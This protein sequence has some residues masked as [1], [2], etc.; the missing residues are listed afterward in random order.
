[1][2]N[3]KA[4]EK[5]QEFKGH[6]A[7]LR[8]TEEAM[9]FGLEI[10]DIEPMAY[11]EVTLVE[12]EMEQLS[13]IWT[14]KEEWDQQWEQW[15]EIRFYDLKIDDMDNDV[16]DFQ[17]KVEKLHKDVRE[18]GVYAYLKNT[19]LQFRETS[20]LLQCLQTDAMRDRHWKELRFEVKDDFDE[21]ADDFN[22]E[23]LSGLNLLN[24]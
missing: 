5:L 15:K 1:M 7:E 12:T 13:E 4:F 17:T 11:P 2:D 8:E 19:I 16:Y 24:H 6:T 23:R 22:L 9:K 10:F 14:I 20:K 21:T 18:W 3:A